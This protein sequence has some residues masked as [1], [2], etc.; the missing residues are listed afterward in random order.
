MM[1][2]DTVP[3]T[4]ALI[5]I[6]VPLVG[7]D[8]VVWPLSVLWLAV[9]GVVVM[10][11]KWLHPPRSARVFWGLVALPLLFLLAWEGGWWLIPAGIAQIAVDAWA[12]R[13]DARR[14]DFT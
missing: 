6:A 4:L 11:V 3:L 2:L 9:L 12:A 13:A 1:F 7:S 5:G 10:A 14:V 8:F